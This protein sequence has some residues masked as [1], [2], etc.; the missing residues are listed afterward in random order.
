MAGYSDIMILQAVA[1]TGR[2]AQDLRS[3]VDA[4]AT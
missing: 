2:K 3:T 1:Q 4:L